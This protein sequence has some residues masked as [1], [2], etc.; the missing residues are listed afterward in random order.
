M[1]L[2]SGGPSPMVL[3]ADGCRTTG[4]DVLLRRLLAEE[5]LVRNVLGAGDA[6]TRREVLESVRE[7]GLPHA[8][9]DAVPQMVLAE[10]GHQP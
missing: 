5:L 4:D 2:H 9:R 1:S 3:R 7:P 10:F 8:L 6:D